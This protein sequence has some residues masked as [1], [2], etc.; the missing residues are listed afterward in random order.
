MVLILVLL[1]IAA[2]ET[3][4]RATSDVDSNADLSR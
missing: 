4:I 3:P 2:C 1:A